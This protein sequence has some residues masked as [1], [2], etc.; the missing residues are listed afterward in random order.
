MRSVWFVVL[1]FLVACQQVV[2]TQNSTQPLS[3]CNPPYH[4]YTPGDCCLDKDANGV[5]DRE[6]QLLAITGSV[7]GVPGLQQPAPS[8]MS[9]I[10]NK[11]R[12]NV[13]DYAFKQGK[14]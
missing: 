3:P 1:V 8:I 4:E 13:S 7:V 6:E 14:D 11:F 5:C 2:P 12:Q 10:I 9:Y